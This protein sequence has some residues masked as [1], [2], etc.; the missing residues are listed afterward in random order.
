[1]MA[2][3]YEEQPKGSGVIHFQHLVRCREIVGDKLWFLIPGV[4]TQGG[5]VAQTVKGAWAGWG[6]MA[7]NSSSEI[8]FAS[9]GEDYIEAAAKKAIELRDAIREAM[10]TEVE[11]RRSL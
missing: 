2:A 8:N 9:A 5:Y 3:A 4:G 10:P 11:I 6:S 7:I 1:V